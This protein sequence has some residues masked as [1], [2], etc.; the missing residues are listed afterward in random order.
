MSHLYV[1]D[2]HAVEVVLVVIE[3]RLLVEQLRHALEAA[4]DAFA[5]GCYLL[6]QILA[7][8]GEAVDG[9]LDL[10]LTA[11]CRDGCLQAQAV[12]GMDAD[13][14]LTSGQGIL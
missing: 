4:V 2:V 14:A 5:L 12:V 1:A 11:F 3:L 10:R 9:C 8:G 13:A 7:L 6:P